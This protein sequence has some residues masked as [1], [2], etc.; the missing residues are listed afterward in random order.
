MHD[1][2]QNGHGSGPKNTVPLAQLRAPF[3]HPDWL[4]EVKYG[5]FRALAYLEHGTVRL[6]S[7]KGNVFPKRRVSYRLESR[8]FLDYYVPVFATPFPANGR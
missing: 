8:V 3:D 5:G 6:V 2:K 1:H 4:F 7:R